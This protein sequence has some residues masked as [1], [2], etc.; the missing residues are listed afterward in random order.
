MSSAIWHGAPGRLHVHTRARTLTPCSMP[1]CAPPRVLDGSLER[2]DAR[3]SNPPSQ[4]AAGAAIVRRRSRT[5]RSFDARCAHRPHL[6]PHVFAGRSRCTR[7]QRTIL[8][9]AS[10]CASA[11]MRRGRSSLPAARPARSSSGKRG[12]QVPAGGSCTRAAGTG[13]HSLGVVCTC[14][15]TGFHNICNM[16]YAEHIGHAH[17][18]FY[19]SWHGC[20]VVSFSEKSIF[21]PSLSRGGQEAALSGSGTAQW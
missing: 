3:H 2:P 19:E 6:G 13:Y 5:R 4:A 16:K 7:R 11:H 18:L 12:G 10:M 17:E 20:E 14:K 1:A 8:G 21:I 9:C 15:T